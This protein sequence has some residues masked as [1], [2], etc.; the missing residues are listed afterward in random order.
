MILPIH[1]KRPVV[2]ETAFV[3][4]SADVIGEVEIGEESS[5][6]FQCVIRGDVNWIRSAR[7]PISRTT[8]CCT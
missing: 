6:W 2:H 8:R 1:G 4:P 5:V 7:A 3:A